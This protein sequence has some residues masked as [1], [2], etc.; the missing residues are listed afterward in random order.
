MANA[1]I[2]KHDRPHA[3]LAGMSGISMLLLVTLVVSGTPALAAS[4]PSGPVSLPSAPPAQRALV[5]RVSNSLALVARRSISLTTV[6]P[7]AT[8]TAHPTDRHPGGAPIPHAQVQGGS[9]VSH[10]RAALLDLPPPCA[11]A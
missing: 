3:R 6:R 8:S 4:R 11:A 10:V 7:Y 9:L 1:R 5:G 2:G